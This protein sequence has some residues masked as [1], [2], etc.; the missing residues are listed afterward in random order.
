[1]RALILFLKGNYR[2][3]FKILNDPQFHWHSYYKEV[4]LLKV[5]NLIALRIKEI[6][7]HIDNLGNLLGQDAAAT[8]RKHLRYGYRPP[9]IV[10]LDN[11]QLVPVNGK[12]EFDTAV[13]TEREYK[14]QQTERILRDY[15]EVGQ[16]FTYQEARQFIHPIRTRT[17]KFKSEDS[18]NGTILREFQFL[19]E[20]GVLKFHADEGRSGIYSLL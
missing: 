10:D 20:R 16:E 3:S 8:L 13:N 15:F 17:V 14:W 1:M 5:L 4:C 2:S 12:V 9:H 7:S 18:F 6:E 11:Q 19:A